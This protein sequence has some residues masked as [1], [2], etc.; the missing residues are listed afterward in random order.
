[1]RGEVYTVRDTSCVRQP[2]SN[3]GIVAMCSV[4][5]FYGGNWILVGDAFHCLSG[6]ATSRDLDEE[7]LDPK[8]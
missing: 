5:G 7:A 3:P 4:E 6:D 2:F 8:S 1:M